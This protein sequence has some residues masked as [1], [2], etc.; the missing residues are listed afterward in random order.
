MM[1]GCAKE[2][3]IARRI[4][5][6]DVATW[7]SHLAEMLSNGSAV[8]PDI[9]YEPDMITHIAAVDERRLFRLGTKGRLAV[10]RKDLQL[11]DEVWILSQG[12]VPFILRPAQHTE[13]RF[14]LID[15]CYVQGTMLG[16]ALT[17]DS[18]RQCTLV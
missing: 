6:T 13:G 4:N 12:R 2:G 1:A 16:Q 7:Q 18:P 17:Q 5:D 10:G 3:A 11:G 14:S 15:P 8:N 9:F